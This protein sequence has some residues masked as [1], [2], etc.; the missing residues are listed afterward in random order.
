MFTID[1][2]EILKNEYDVFSEKWK[3]GRGIPKAIL[4]VL[5]EQTDRYACKKMGIDNYKQSELDENS[6][7]KTIKI[8]LVEDLKRW[9]T[10]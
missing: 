8:P 2:L 3:V 6:L 5:F 7:Y 1:D 9:Y 10:G 4:C